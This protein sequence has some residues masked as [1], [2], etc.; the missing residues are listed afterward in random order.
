[1]INAAALNRSDVTARRIS[2]SSIA[3]EDTDLYF[4]WFTSALSVRIQ[5]SEAHATVLSW[6]HLTALLDES[7]NSMLLLDRISRLVESG[8][9]NPKSFETKF[10]KH[11]DLVGL[12]A[13]VCAKAVFVTQEEQVIL[14]TNSS[15]KLYLVDMD[16]GAANTAGL[17]VL[18]DMPQAGVYVGIGVDKF[19]YNF[20]RGATVMYA[21]EG[22]QTSQWNF[23]LVHLTNNKTI[24]WLTTIDASIVNF[25]S[26]KNNIYFEVTHAYML[27]VFDA[28]RN[29]VLS[30]KRQVFGEPTPSQLKRGF[31]R[32]FF[33]CIPETI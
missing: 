10:V 32:F 27:W 31:V 24:T 16:N 33:L 3:S 19:E 5:T 4:K 15:G 28:K 1:M 25:E 12:D 22:P 7:S 18:T 17:E 2:D 13:S 20:R 6:L 11:I 23:G 8:S 26:N 21:Y 14:A 30:S 29:V 9:S